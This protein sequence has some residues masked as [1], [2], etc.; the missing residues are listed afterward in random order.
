MDVSVHILIARDQGQVKGEFFAL[1]FVAPFCFFLLKRAPK[2]TFEAFVF[3]W[4]LFRL[5]QPQTPSLQPLHLISFY[6][7][8]GVI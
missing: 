1:V 8:K 3:A 2:Y 6:I 4:C 7:S 5:N